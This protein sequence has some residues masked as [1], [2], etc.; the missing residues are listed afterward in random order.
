MKNVLYT[1]YH[2]IEFLTSQHVHVSQGS[3]GIWRT[4]GPQRAT[5]LLKATQPL[6]C[7]SK[8]G[9]KKEEEKEEVGDAEGERRRQ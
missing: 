1:S 3:G 2:L 7:R 5:G 8:T 4:Q 9:L 6:Y